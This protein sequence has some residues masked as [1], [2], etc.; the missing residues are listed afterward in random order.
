M[1]STYNPLTKQM[2][3]FETIAGAR[4]QIYTPPP[5]LTTTTKYVAQ[6]KTGTCDWRWVQNEVWKVIPNYTVKLRPDLLI[7]PGAEID[8]SAKVDYQDVDFLWSTGENAYGIVAKPTSSTTYTV[9][10]TLRTVGVEYR[11]RERLG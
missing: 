10:A 7:C 2:N 9:T 3:P 11:C 5:N 6:V 1:K 8:L 4:G